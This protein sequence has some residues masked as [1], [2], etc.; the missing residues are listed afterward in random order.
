[1]NNT[2]SFNI[3]NKYISFTLEI[4]KEK[5]FIEIKLCVFWHDFFF[6]AR[7]IN[8]GRPF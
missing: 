2:K 4:I 6:Y 5:I 7:F 3:I 1:M 8:N